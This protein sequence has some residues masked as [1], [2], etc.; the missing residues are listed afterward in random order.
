MRKMHRAAITLVVALSLS[1]AV[2]AASTGPLEEFDAIRTQQ[3][4]MR[5]DIVAGTGRY[6]GL[7]QRTRDQLVRRQDEVLRAIDG[8]QSPDEL[9]ESER[10]ALFNDLE[11]IEA[12]VNNAD[13]DRMV[14]ERVTTIGSTMKRRVCKTAAQVRE[15]REQARQEMERRAVEQTRTN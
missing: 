15:D 6:A 7:S 1:T 14:C 3:T 11:W 12:T 10:L 13:D 5:S 9:S 4:Q 2:S 8:K